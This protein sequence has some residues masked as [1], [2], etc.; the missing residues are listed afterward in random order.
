MAWNPKVH[1]TQLTGITTQQYFSTSVTLSLGEICHV[2][3]EGTFPGNP[4]DP[5]LVQCYSTL[6]ASS[7]QWD[8]QPFFSVVIQPTTPVVSFI[9]RDYYKFRVGAQ[10]L[11]STDTLIADM[12]SRTAIQL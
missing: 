10:R 11:G 8:S 1:A 6:D 12:W 9:V 7:E 4:T 2:Q 5:L 3:I